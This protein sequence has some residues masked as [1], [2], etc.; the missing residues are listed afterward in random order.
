MKILIS[1]TYYSPYI[2]GLTRTAQTIAEGLAQKGHQVTILCIKHDHKLSNTE[3]LNGVRIIRAR[4]MMKIS[5]GFLSGDFLLKTL[6]EVKKTDAVLI[7]LPQPEGC[8]VA[9]WAKL[10]RKQVTALYQC[11]V[12]LP[13]GIFHKYI[14]ELA[15]LLNGV[16]LRL[17]DKIIVGTQDY[18]EHSRLVKH[19]LNKTEGVLFPIE[20]ISRQ[21]KKASPKLFKFKKGDK[22]ILAGLAGR[23]AAE[24]GIEYA[25]EAVSLFNNTNPEKKAKLLIAGPPNP[26]GEEIYRQKI[27]GLVKMHKDDVIML[28]QLKDWEMQHFYRILDMLLLPSLN[29]T[30]SLGIVQVE[31]MREGVPAIV[32]DLPGVRVPVQLTGMG[33]ITPPADSKSLSQAMAEIV[34]HKDKYQHRETARKMFDYQTALNIYEAIILSK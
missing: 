9:W 4:P 16:T 8:W 19:Y 5:K 33:I 18:A 30:E 25:I 27:L 13:G 6:K 3:V 24:K 10:R 14:Q 1:L 15:D 22:K 26:V 34:N 28:G 2:S 23:M 17:A 21:P 11:D 29:L 20:E 7:N 31:A 12:V 32:S